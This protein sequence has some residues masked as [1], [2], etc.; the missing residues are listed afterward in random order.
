MCLFGSGGAV[1]RGGH[2]AQRAEAADAPEHRGH[3]QPDPPHQRH[4]LHLQGGRRRRL[5]RPHPARYARYPLYPSPTYF[6][7]QPVPSTTGVTKAGVCAILLYP[8]PTYFPFQP[9]PSTTGVTKAGVCAILLYPSPTYFPFQPVPPTTGV[10]KAVVCAILLYPSPTYFP[11]QPVPQRSL[12]VRWVVRSIL[13]G[14]DPL[15][16]FSLSVGWCI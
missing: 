9:V 4:P 7:F 10:T 16:Y 14:V 3:P 12:M 15:S 6:S 11:F 1:W 5:L 2:L 8:S 13:H